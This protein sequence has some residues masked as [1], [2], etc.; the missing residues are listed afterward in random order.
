MADSMILSVWKLNRLPIKKPRQSR[1]GITYRS[2]KKVDT[3]PLIE[4]IRKDNAAHN[5]RVLSKFVA[6]GFVEPW[7]FVKEAPF[8]PPDLGMNRELFLDALLLNPSIAS[9][10]G[11]PGSPETRLEEMVRDKMDRQTVYSLR[12]GWLSIDAVLPKNRRRIAIQ[13]ATPSW[14]DAA[15]AKAVYAECRKMNVERPAAMY[16]VDH[17]VPIQG[18]DVCGLN[19]HW[20]LQIIPRNANRKKSNFFDIE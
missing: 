6:S 12:R 13:L 3:A 15:E 8:S 19:V 16:E 14:A 11:E 7:E 17:I 9:V 20:N 5:E 10:L 18:K 4:R 2:K 1:S